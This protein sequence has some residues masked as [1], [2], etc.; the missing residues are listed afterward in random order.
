MGSGP[1]AS[2]AAG[3]LRAS[4]R[5]EGMADPDGLLGRQRPPT[6]VSRSLTPLPAAS[7]SGSPLISMSSLCGSI[8]RPDRWGR[9]VPPGTFQGLPQPGLGGP[10]AELLVAWPGAGGSAELGL[11]GERAGLLQE[12][13]WQP[14]QTSVQALA[15]TSARQRW[16]GGPLRA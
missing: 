12:P 14:W 11:V 7:L 6:P 3:P 5:R 4:P 16:A 15:R 9:A 2:E 8:L 13:G 1:F 10:P